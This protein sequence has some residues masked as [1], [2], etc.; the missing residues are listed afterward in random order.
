MDADAVARFIRFY[1]RITRRNLASLPAR[2]DAV[3]PIDEG[4]AVTA[5]RFRD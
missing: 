2:A 1:E 4:H 5:C 3:L